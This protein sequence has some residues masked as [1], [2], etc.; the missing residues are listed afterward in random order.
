MDAKFNGIKE[1]LFFI[2]YITFNLADAFIQSN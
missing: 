2:D 1:S